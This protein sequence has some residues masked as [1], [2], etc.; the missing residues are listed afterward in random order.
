PAAAGFS[1]ATERRDADLDVA[2]S[3]SFGF[4]GVNSSLI[5]KRWRG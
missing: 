5:F 4:G 2:M 1:I 3:N